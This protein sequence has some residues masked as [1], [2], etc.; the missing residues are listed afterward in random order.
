MLKWSGTENS[1]GS[2]VPQTSP[3]QLFKR[4][5]KF[6]RSAVFGGNAVLTYQQTEQANGEHS[7]WKPRFRGA[8]KPLRQTECL[9]LQR[10]ALCQQWI[11]VRMRLWLGRSIPTSPTEM[12]SDFLE[13]NELPHRTF[14]SLRHT[15][16]TLSLANGTDI[17][18]VAER[19]G[20]S[21]IKTTNRYV[22][23]IETTERKAAQTLGN[24]IQN[25]AN[26]AE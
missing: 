10:S 9:L 25:L 20:H 19:L 2:Y 18:S 17:K 15:S 26:R 23:A 8:D 5:Q 24:Y 14:H 6:R 4:R 12:F 7:N 13:R 21:Q 11:Y 1:K 16:A 22:H 3:L